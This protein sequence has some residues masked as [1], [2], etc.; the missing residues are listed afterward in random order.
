MVDLYALSDY[1]NKVLEVDKFDDYAPNGLQVE[2]RDVVRKL[3]SGVTASH[4][5]IEAAIKAKADAI[6][7]H[8]GYFWKGEDPRVIGMKQ[9]RLRS[10]LANQVSL[11]AYHLPLD[12]H[13]K[14]GNNVQLA[15]RL[16]F[17]IAGRFGRGTVP[18]ALHGTVSPSQSPEKLKHLLKQHLGRE[19]LLV[20][21]GGNEVVR[22][23]WCTGAAQSYIEDAAALGLDAFISGEVS[24][25]TYHIAQEMGIHYYAAGHHA[26]ERFGPLAFGDHLARHFG[27]E[28]EFIDI[29]N[30]V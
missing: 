30:P 25:P 17:D 19:P 21:G 24:E 11:V 28:H 8:H 27:L 23:G 2:G 18:L 13:P 15:I 12:A 4:A 10:L 7:V 6:L 3:V 22:I 5:L 20:R 14:W 16:G 1:A 29:E 9:R 26:T